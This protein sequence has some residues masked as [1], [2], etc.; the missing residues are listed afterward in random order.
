MFNFLLTAA[1]RFQQSSCFI[2]SARSDALIY[3]SLSIQMLM[4]HCCDIESK[5]DKQSPR[6]GVKLHRLH[7]QSWGVQINPESDIVLFSRWSEQE[8]CHLHWLLLMFWTS[9]LCFQ[10][11]FCS[12]KILAVSLGFV[13]LFNFT[14][15]LCYKFRVSTNS[16]RL[17]MHVGN[18]RK[19]E[20]NMDRK[21]LYVEWL[22]PANGKVTQSVPRTSMN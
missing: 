18:K 20:N 15:S 2:S 10:P 14:V 16:H 5:Q 1:E 17:K 6:A 22:N 12:P 4:Q 8:F 7:T 9:Q 19:S 13:K 21:K 11:N 3:E